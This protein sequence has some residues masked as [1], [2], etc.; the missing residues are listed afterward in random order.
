MDEPLKAEHLLVRLQCFPLNLILVL[1]L[2]VH[3]ALTS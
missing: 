3:S 1:P 2:Q